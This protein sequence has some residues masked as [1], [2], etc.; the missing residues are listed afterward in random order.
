[1]IADFGLARV[2]D[3]GDL[4]RTICGTPSY[5][6]P[7]IVCRSSATTPYSKSVDI[8][9]LGVVLY[10]L[11]LNSFPFSKMPLNNEPGGQSVEAYSKASK[12]TDTNL[13]YVCLSE[14]LRDLLTSML[15]VDPSRRIE[16]DATVI[17]PWT[18]TSDNGVPGLLFEAHD[19]WGVLQAV[20]L[21]DGHITAPDWPGLPEISLFRGQTVIGRSRS[22]HIQIPD[23]RISAQHCTIAL[24]DSHVYLSNTGRGPCWAN[25]RPLA[26]G[27]TTLLKSPYVFHLCAPSPNTGTKDG[28]DRHSGYSF[29]IEMLAKPWMQTW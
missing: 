25:D 26:N 10:A 18:Q 28:H 2:V 14:P 5:L 24:K 20:N 21:R 6:A 29:R 19:I 3:D 13:K 8:W 4:M 1:M 23:H 17:H 11:H 9:A 15:Q 7:E 16:I 27:Q 12:L 22:S